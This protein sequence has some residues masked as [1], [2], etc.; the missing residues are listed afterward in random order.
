MK[1]KNKIMTLGLAAIS[2]VAMSSCS[3]FLDEGPKT[4]LPEDIIYSDTAYVESNVQTLYKNWRGLFTDRYLWEQMVGTDEI[5]SG[6]YQALKE[7]GGRRGSLDKYDALLTS[8]LSYVVEQWENRWPTV[9]EAA[10]IVNSL[11]K[12]NLDEDKKVAGLYGEAS[13]IRGGL[14]ME[15][16]MLYGRI[17]IIDVSRQD[18][19]GY[20]RQ[21]LKD[22]WQFI[23]NDLKNAAQ[24]CPE[25][26]N[27]GRATRYAASMMLGYAYMAAPEETG[28]RDF[29][30]A[31]DALE[32]VV[33]GPFKLVAYYD[34]WDYSIT[35]TSESIL[36]W[37]F[38]N[39]YPDCNSV[40]FQIGSRA[41]QSYFGDGCYYSGYDHAVPSQWA[42]SNVED[43]GI[44]EDGDIRKEESI[45]Y[46][47]TYYGQTPTLDNILWEELGDDHDEQLQRFFKTGEGEY[48]HGDKFLGIKV[49][50]TRSVARRHKTADNDTLR[51]LMQSEW[52]EI[53]LCAL[54]IM[55]EK[56][57]KADDGA[58]RELTD[59]YLSVTDRINNWDLV[60]LSA[61]HIVGT[62]LLDKPRDLLYTLAGSPLLWDNR[63]AMVATYA[64]IKQGDLDDT[65]DLALRFISHPH[66]LMHKATGWMLREAGKRD[67]GRL[68]AF[69]ME[70]H[71]QMP[72]TML[73]YAIEKF[74]EDE[75]KMILRMK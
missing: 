12:L 21:P 22:V 45:R 59:M 25:T 17:P 40:Q 33:K 58:R 3:D 24:Y 61:P 18:E 74:P 71:A 70:H 44:W 51:R 53:R 56:M 48:G 5:Q 2:A 6:A 16:A 57:K 35:N 14:M 75:R 34:L 28:L 54:L 1:I 49:P 37:Q 8:E 38:N 23:I 72:R 41:V 10:K 55:V 27:P 62:Y 7:D 4:S 20:G 43:G 68:R 29:S 65:Y 64:F 30:L 9:S 73:R 19:L 36:E 52:H 11:G 26:N 69:V 39:V 15:L 63:I 47:F 13:F 60:D 50:A 46:D 31:K 32:T 67:M 66:E 42:Y